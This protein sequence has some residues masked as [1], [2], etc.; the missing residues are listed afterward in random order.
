MKL[1]GKGINLE[2]PGTG[3]GSQKKKGKE[4]GEKDRTPKK[5]AT[6]PVWIRLLIDMVVHRNIERFFWSQSGS[7]TKLTRRRLAPPVPQGRAWP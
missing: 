5:K 2:T 7:A 1:I 3:G 6:K 4:I